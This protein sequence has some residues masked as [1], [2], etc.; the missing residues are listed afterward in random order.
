[1]AGEHVGDRQ[2]REDTAVAT[3][4][5]AVATGSYAQ[6]KSGPQDRL[7]IPC[8]LNAGIRSLSLPVL[9]P[10]LLIRF[11]DGKIFHH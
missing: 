5:G 9:Y 1:V 3:E 4:P 8:L 6:L 11:I 2:V 10:S 7:K